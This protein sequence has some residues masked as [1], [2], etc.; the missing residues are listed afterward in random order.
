[1]LTKRQ[2]IIFNHQN[3]INNT[4][5]LQQYNNYL[6][7]ELN[8]YE[9]NESRQYEQTDLF[10]YTED[11]MMRTF[12]KNEQATLSFEGLQPVIIIYALGA[13]ASLIVFALEVLCHRI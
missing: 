11:D 3:A 2:I 1:M 8:T 9:L 12:L 7:E 10:N 5:E 6:V 13:A 4:R